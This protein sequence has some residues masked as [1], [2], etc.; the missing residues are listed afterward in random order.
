ML[1]KVE[2]LITKIN[3][4]LYLDYSQFSFP[5]SRTRYQKL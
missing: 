2:R 3:C 4:I 5:N 1:E